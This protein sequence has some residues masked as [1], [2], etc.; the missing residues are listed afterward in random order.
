MNVTIFGRILVASFGKEMDKLH[1][2][3]IYFFEETFLISL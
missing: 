1:K 2:L 3:T